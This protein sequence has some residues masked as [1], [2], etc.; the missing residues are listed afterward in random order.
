[1]RSPAGRRLGAAITAVLAACLLQVL[2]A[3]GTGTAPASPPATQP[4]G[5]V[6]LNQAPPSD[7]LIG[8]GGSGTVS[9]NG[10][11]YG[12]AIGG[13]GVD[14][15]AVAL[16]ATTGQ[17]YR[18]SDIALFAGTY[19]QLS[20]AVPRPS[21]DTGGLWIQNEHGVVIHLRSPPQG[22]IPALRG[23]ALRVVLDQ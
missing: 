13:V 21:Q 17:A 14:G 9:F 2:A 5:T 3:C 8:G 6:E 20:D 7:A 19:R 10:K 11:V 16:L 4:A 15:S 1:V 23:D 12:F 22:H 18:L